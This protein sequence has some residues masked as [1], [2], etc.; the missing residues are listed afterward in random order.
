SSTLAASDPLGSLSTEFAAL[1]IQAGVQVNDVPLTAS[2]LTGPP[3]RAALSTGKA[4]AFGFQIRV[5]NRKGGS[6][7]ETFTGVVAFQGGTAW[8]LAAGPSPGSSIPPA[9]SVLGSGG[10]VWKATAGNETAQLQAEGSACRFPLP[11]AVTSC[12]FAS[13]TNAGFDITASGPVSAGATGSK[14]ASMTA[15][16]LTGGVSLV[17]DCNI[18]SVCPGAGPQPITVTVSPNPVT[19]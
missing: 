1:A 16:K 14:T 2:L 10:Q 8:V 19:V 13:F 15:T 12:K 11:S 17:V 7:P 3:D 5:L 6:S 9:L 4:Q 18:G